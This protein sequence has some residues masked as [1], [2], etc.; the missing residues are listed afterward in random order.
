LGWTIEVDRRA[1][2]DLKQ[3]DRTTQQ[4]ILDCLEKRVTIAASPRDFGEAV[5][6][7][8]TGLWRYRVGDYRVICH[9]EDAQLV[10]LVVRIGR[11]RDAY[12]REDEWGV[13]RRTMPPCHT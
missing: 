12:A 10:L 13:R 2:H 8:F 11:R 7:T 6:S 1:V 5:T 9:I 3:L 4:C